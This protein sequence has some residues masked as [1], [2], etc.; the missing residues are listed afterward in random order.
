MNSNEVEHFEKLFKVDILKKLLNLD[1]ELTEGT[2]TRGLK[3]DY[4]RTLKFIM[5]GFEE[6]IKFERNKKS[7]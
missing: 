6:G 4:E 5:Y 7:K 1:N 2:V 3:S